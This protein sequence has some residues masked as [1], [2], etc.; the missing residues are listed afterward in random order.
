MMVKYTIGIDFGYHDNL[1][2]VLYHDDSGTFGKSYLLDLSGNKT[3]H[4]RKRSEK[5][6]GEIIEKVASVARKL[7]L[8]AID[9]EKIT[10]LP[11]RQLS[12]DLILLQGLVTGVL[13]HFFSRFEPKVKMLR[14]MDA[15]KH[16]SIPVAKKDIATA[17]KKRKTMDLVKKITG[18]PTVNEHESDAMLLVLYYHR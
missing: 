1:A 13:V 6:I 7:S 16:F 12:Y 11:E 14:N 10:I 2:F 17:L 15:C 8:D 18:L 5:F 9:A 4:L 3:L